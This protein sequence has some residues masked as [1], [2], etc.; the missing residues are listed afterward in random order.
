MTYQ[1]EALGH[2]ERLG[3]ISGLPVVSFLCV[4]IYL[5]ALYQVQNDPDCFHHI[6]L[7]K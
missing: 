4:C 3:F 5:S 7:T 2:M 1:E 6:N